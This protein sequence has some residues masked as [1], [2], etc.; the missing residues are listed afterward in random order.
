MASHVVPIHSDVYWILETAVD[1]RMNDQFLTWE[2][3][4]VK[5]LTFVQPVSSSNIDESSYFANLVK[6]KWFRRQD[7]RGS[8]IIATAVVL[9]NRTKLQ[10]G[11]CERGK[12][13]MIIVGTE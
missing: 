8:T 4:Y 12:Y 11:V 5:N 7:F 6:N 10:C 1:T 3:Y 13:V 2:T 9:N